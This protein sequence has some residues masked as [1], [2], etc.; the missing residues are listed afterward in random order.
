MPFTGAQL[1]LSG[2]DT[3]ARAAPFEIGDKVHVHQDRGVMVGTMRIYHRLPIIST[4]TQPE[5]GGPN[6]NRAACTFAIEVGEL[7]I[8]FGGGSNDRVHRR[9]AKKSNPKGHAYRCQKDYETR[10]TTC[11]CHDQL[12]AAGEVQKQNQRA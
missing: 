1:C 6:R 10:T 9:D 2:T 5:A 11:P 3:P 8:L 12:T 7:I 4:L